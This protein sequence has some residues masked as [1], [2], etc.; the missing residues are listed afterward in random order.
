M[1]KAF[2]FL[3]ALLFIYTAQAQNV[4]IGTATP[5]ASAQLDVSSLCK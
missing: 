1:K 3:I 5:A 4:G 2:S